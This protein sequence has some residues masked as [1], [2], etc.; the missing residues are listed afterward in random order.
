MATGT[1]TPTVA[2]GAD[3]PTLETGPAPSTGVA[4]PTL[5][6]GPAPKTVAVEVPP[7]ILCNEGNTFY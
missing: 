4:A 3:A 1:A 2:V 5:E 6:T 7:I